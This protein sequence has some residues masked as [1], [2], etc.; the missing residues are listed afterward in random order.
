MH[1][2][3][4]PQISS[5]F[6]LKSIKFIRG[7][8]YVLL[9]DCSVSKQAFDPTLQKKLIKKEIR[10]LHLHDIFFYKTVTNDD[11]IIIHDSFLTEPGISIISISDVSMI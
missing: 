10:H 1:R 7:D 11:C 8:L 2:P 3:F 4:H 9:V 5:I 6:N